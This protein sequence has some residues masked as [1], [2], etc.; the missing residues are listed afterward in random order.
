M[1]LARIKGRFPGQLSHL[2]LLNDDELKNFIIETSAEGDNGKEGD[3]DGGEERVDK[4]ARESGKDSKNNKYNKKA[5]LQS[6][7][8]T[9]SAFSSAYVELPST[10]PVQQLE[11]STNE[12]TNNIHGGH[13]A[14]YLFQS[15]SRED[16]GQHQRVG[17]HVS[18]QNVSPSAQIQAMD[19]S[20]DE[21]LN[22]NTVYTLVCPLAPQSYRDGLH[23]CH[24]VHGK[25]SITRFRPLKYNS[26][27]DTTLVECQLLTGRTHQS[28]LT[29]T[30]FVCIS[31][32]IQ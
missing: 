15:M 30:R 1:Y 8:G 22:T 18:T 10:D 21:T 20:K 32:S 27:D 13:R 7:S 28:K 25:Q 29:V 31:F 11:S 26:V 2:R 5:K 17:Y 4:R 16:I 14:H 9:A 3:D 23:A 6:A 24:P 12:I 19:L